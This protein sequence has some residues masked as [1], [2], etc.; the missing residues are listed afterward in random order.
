MKVKVIFSSPFPCL[1]RRPRGRIF[2]HEHNVQAKETHPPFIA[3][4]TDKSQPRGINVIHSQRFSVR[5]AP[6]LLAH[7]GRLYTY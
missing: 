2:L 7:V 4:S 6:V 1:D 3:P 5:L